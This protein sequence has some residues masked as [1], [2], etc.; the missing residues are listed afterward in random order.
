MDIVILLLDNMLVKL[1][2]FLHVR[3]WVKKLTTLLFLAMESNFGSMSPSKCS[4]NGN[5]SLK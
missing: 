1:R 5:R 2:H 4:D 3:P